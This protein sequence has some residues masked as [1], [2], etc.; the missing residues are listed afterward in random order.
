MITPAVFYPLAWGIILQSFF[1]LKQVGRAVPG[2]LK[3]GRFQEF[4]QGR[5]QRGEPAN[6]LIAGVCL[7]RR[8]KSSR[9]S[10]NRER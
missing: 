5:A 10:L 8:R 7:P 2:A 6:P 4:N 1:F 9:K 3:T